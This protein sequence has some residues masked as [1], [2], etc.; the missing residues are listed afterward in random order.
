MRSQPSRTRE[1][2]L[3]I[4]RETLH[5]LRFCPDPDVDPRTRAVF[6]LALGRRIAILEAES[7]EARR[8]LNRPGYV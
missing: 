3:E 8:L 7:A 5:G 6:K 1:E 4:L 2:I